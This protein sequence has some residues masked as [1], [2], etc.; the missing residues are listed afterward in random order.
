MKRSTTYELDPGPK[1][2]LW[3]IIWACLINF[4]IHLFPISLLSLFDIYPS[5]Y[6]QEIALDHTGQ[7][8]EKLN[9]ANATVEMLIG[10]VLQMTLA[11]L[12]VAWVVIREMFRGLGRGRQAIVLKL[13]SYV[14]LLGLIGFGWGLLVVLILK[15]F[16]AFEGSRLGSAPQ[17]TL[18]A[19]AG[20]AVLSLISAFAF[21]VDPAKAQA[22]L[23]NM[24]ATRRTNGW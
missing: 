6:A 1:R 17:F 9:R 20:L 24:R 8:Q 3:I 23:S 22:N 7:L 13:D 10:L 5:V 11:A 21:L 18:F 2:I 15:G 19:V 12:M 16:A 4:V 14:L